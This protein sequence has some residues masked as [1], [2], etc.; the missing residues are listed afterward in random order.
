[1]ATDPYGV[2]GVPR[3]ASADEIKSAFRKLARQ[4][5]PDVNPNDPTAEDKFKEVSAAYEI[6]SDPQK[7][8]RYDQFGVTDDQQGGGPGG[9][10]FQDV[11]VGDIFEAFFGGMGGQRRRTNGVDGEDVRAEVVLQLKD[12]LQSSERKFTYR[13]N[14]KCSTCGGN[15]AR[16][17]TQPVTCGTCQG[18]GVVGRVQQTILGSIRTQTT[19]PTCQGT[20]R[21]IPDPCPTCRARG[22][23]AVT[24]ELTVTIPAGIEEGT[25]LRV[26]GKGSDG[27]GM[28]RPGD[29]YV[30]VH[31]AEDSR[32]ERE[33]RDLFASLDLTFA[34]AA[35]GDTVTIEGLTGPV[36]LSVEAG[37]QPGA[38]KRVKGEGVPKLN[39]GPRGDLV[40]EFGVLVPKR[41]SA[42]EA[43]LLREFARK[44]GEPVPEGPSGGGFLG[45]LF[46][47]KKK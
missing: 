32:F 46:G 7:R 31:V 20:G 1:M 28:G 41:L 43:D 22:R 14:A 24:A 6:L 17:G 25:T 21:S 35:I 47:K 27:I 38:T 2:L 26:G 30:T 23:E 15:G 18:Q 16:P 4:Y 37:T 33:G 39:G 19:C 36:E 12:V 13:R 40:V 44:R 3:D 11:G 45:G 5:H 34:Q 29:L 8:A 9:D 10:F 42:E